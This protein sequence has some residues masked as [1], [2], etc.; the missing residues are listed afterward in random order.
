MI[1][2]EGPPDGIGDEEAADV[3]LRHGT[4]VEIPGVPGSPLIV[5]GQVQDLLTRNNFDITFVGISGKVVKSEV[6]IARKIWF[7][8]STLNLKSDRKEK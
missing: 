8:A 5:S 6:K 4:E 2:L 1:Q 3:L 7:A